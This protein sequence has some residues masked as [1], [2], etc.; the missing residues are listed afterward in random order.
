MDE[1]TKKDIARF[2]FG[3]IADL[4]GNRR[5]GRGEKQRLLHDK[6]S[7]EW[8]IPHSRRI[9]ISASTI[10][11]WLRRYERSGGRIESLYPEHRSDINVTRALDADTAQALVRLKKE[12]R[13]VTLPT[14]LREARLR[15]LVPGH[16][17]VS[18]ATLYRFFKREGLDREE[19]AP[20]DRRKFEAELP[21]DIWQSDAMHA[22]KVAEEGKLRKAYLFAFI[23]D[24]SRLIPHAQFYLRE[25]LDCYSD[26]LRQALA[27]RGLPR[28]LYVDNGPTFSSRHLGH[29]TASLGIA[30]I[31]SQ[32]YKPEGRGKIER[33]FRTVR[34]RFLSLIPEG[35][36]LGELNRR[37][38][39]WLESD[40]HRAPH[41]AT[42][43]CPLDRYL[44]HVHLIREAPRDLDD[45]FRRRALR[46]VAR[47]RTVAL[48][49]RLYEAPVELIGQQVSLLYH[50]HDPARVEIQRAGAPAGWLVPLDLNVNCRIRRRHVL[51]IVPPTAPPATP[52]RPRNGQLFSGGPDDEL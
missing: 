8:T 30:L 32:P 14:F 15:G 36:S 45:Y 23:D 3:V 47:D 1:E 5:L 42:R 9:R 52:P 28:K 4:V 34:E 40:Y 51:E 6:G 46:Q 10:L 35:L 12:L 33:W 44:R 50:E 20:I 26:A 48:N 21:N 29:V 25:H 31:H 13:G 37:L 27:K 11:D 7:A 17:R 22:L 41:S 49:G 38:A 18:R 39:E 2:R 24:M 16:F 19:S 43:E